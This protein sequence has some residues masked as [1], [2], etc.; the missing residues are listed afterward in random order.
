MKFL[1]DNALSPQFAKALRAAGHD[2]IHVRER[3]LQHA[4][5]EEIFENAT[6]EGRILVSA[7]TDFG[8]IL[9]LRGEQ[10]ASVILF[11]HP[12]PR[13]PEKQA[14]LLLANLP[15]IAED[16]RLGAIVIIHQD[17]IRIR[18]LSPEKD[19]KHS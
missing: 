13:Q 8:A 15:R 3:N 4:K 16:L 1:I 6:V 11:R 14:Q 12:S 5:D 18:R 7:D 19:A 9:T 2:A 17:R 10:H